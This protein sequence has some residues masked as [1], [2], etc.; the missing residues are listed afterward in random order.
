MKVS[1]EKLLHIAKLAN[2]RIDEDKMET[3]ISGLEDILGMAEVLNE[4]DTSDVN[5]IN[6]E[7]VQY[8]VFREDVVKKF[9]ADKKIEI[10][11]PKVL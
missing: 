1:E 5:D 9:E 7:E 6:L 11:V 10:R 8:N 4:V 2:I 3:Y